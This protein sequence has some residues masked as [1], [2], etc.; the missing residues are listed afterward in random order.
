VRCIEL[1]IAN[2]PERGDRVQIYNQT[3]EVHRVIDL[4]EIVA[5]LTGAEIDLVDNPRK[6]A[7]QNEL[8]VENQRLLGLGLKPT[9]LQ[10]SLLREV[11]QVAGKYLDRVD[12]S[13]IP[14]TSR[15]VRGREDEGE[16]TPSL[17]DGG[18][19]RPSP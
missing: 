13:M 7:P 16:L 15:W 17:S 9:T 18:A 10:E 12:R 4:A 19:A 11:T 5:G 14:C 3:T 2:P 8:A 1:A 6:E